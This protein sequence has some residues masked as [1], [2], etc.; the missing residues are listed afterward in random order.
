M[1]WPHIKIIMNRN[2]PDK[3]SSHII[4]NKYNELS[5]QNNPEQP[6]DSSYQVKQERLNS[7]LLRILTQ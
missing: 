4:N 2:S 7:E 3:Q 5:R 6:S 1:I